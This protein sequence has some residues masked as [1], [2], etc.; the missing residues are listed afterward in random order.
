VL[1]ICAH[2][3][4][5]LAKW[6]SAAHGL[7][8]LDLAAPSA[9]RPDG[10][11]ARFWRGNGPEKVKEDCVHYCMPGVVDEFSTLILNWLASA[12]RG[13]LMSSTSS[14]ANV[15]IVS[16]GGGWRQRGR[17]DG[18][19]TRGGGNRTRASG[20]RTRAGG[21]GRGTSS[22]ARDQD[23]DLVAVAPPRTTTSSPVNGTETA[24]GPRESE[25]LEGSDQTATDAAAITS[26]VLDVVGRRLKGGAKTAGRGGP[27]PGGKLRAT[28]P[29]GAAHAGSTALDQNDGGR[30]E[31]GGPM[32]SR[33]FSVPLNRWLAERGASAAFE[34]CGGAS[35]PCLPTVRLSRQIWW[36]FNCSG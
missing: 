1:S 3:P 11:M 13:L 19:R 29:A 7:H 4:Q 27:S 2:R 15:R 6:L 16:G 20:N 31:L 18:N 32:R 33:F 26:A 36:P 24:A 8:F 25:Q 14:S 12:R 10:A 30:A 22:G 23:T 21:L 5:G 35:A 28:S 17:G 9:M 34:R